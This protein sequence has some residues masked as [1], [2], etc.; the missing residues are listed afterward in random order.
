[1]LLVSFKLINVYYVFFLNKIKYSKTF[2]THARHANEIH[3]AFIF[4]P[5][6]MNKGNNLLFNFVQWPHEITNLSIKWTVSWGKIFSCRQNWNLVFELF[7]N[8]SDAINYGHWC[9]WC[10]ELRSLMSLMLSVTVA[11]VSDAISY[12][13]WCLWCRQ[14]GGRPTNVSERQL[15]SHEHVIMSQTVTVTWTCDYVTDN[16]SHMNMWLRHR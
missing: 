3:T 14:F 15:P 7:D 8:V 16:Y 13:H 4:L 12:G 9:L 10:R 6:K 11:D 5:N 2:L 1:M